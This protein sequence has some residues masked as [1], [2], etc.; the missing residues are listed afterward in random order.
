[1][2]HS[3]DTVEVQLGHKI[4]NSRAQQGYSWDIVGTQLGHKVIWGTVEAK[5]VGHSWGTISGK[6]DGNL[7][8]GTVETQ[9][10]HILG[11]RLLCTQLGHS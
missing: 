9:L 4:E 2:G 5:P 7:I 1:M 8:W 6:N 10:G 11:I 3:W